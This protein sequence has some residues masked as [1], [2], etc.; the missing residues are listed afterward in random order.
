MRISAP[1]SIPEN[2]VGRAFESASKASRKDR[3]ILMGRWPSSGSQDGPA[4]P[5]RW[6]I[7][8]VWRRYEETN[9]TLRCWASP[10][11]RI[12]D[13]Q[14]S[15]PRQSRGELTF[16]LGG[17]SIRKLKNGRWP[18]IVSGRSRSRRQSRGQTSEGRSCNAPAIAS[19][20][21]RSC[22]RWIRRATTPGL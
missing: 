5:G 1:E 2:R 20:I 16:M 17:P 12:G 22:S 8:P 19:F 6:S 21:W 14:L 4:A 7:R 18:A 10:P 3:A 13:A 11:G 9:L 15:P